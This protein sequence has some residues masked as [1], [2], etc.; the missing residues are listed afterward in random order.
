MIP[1]RLDSWEVH[2]PSACVL[3]EYGAP[4]VLRWQQVELPQPAAGQIRLRVRAAGVGP[5]DLEIR[6]GDLRAIF[7]LTADS[8]LGFEASGV[9]DALG[10]GVQ[11]I[12]VGDEVA[13]WLPSLGGYAEYALASSW[14]IKSQA[15]SFVDAAALP[16]SVEA[17]VGV[18]DQLGVVE[19][20]IV[21]ILG[22]AGSVGTIATQIAL[23][24]GATVI[25]AASPRDHELLRELG[26]APVTYGENLVEQVREISS[27]VD[28]VMDAAGRGSLA[29]AIELAGGTE[30]VIT[31]SDPHAQDFGVRLSAPTPDRAPGAVAQGMALLA[32]GKL[33]MKQRRELPMQHA[34]EAHRLLES[35]ETHDKVVLTIG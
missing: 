17:A 12:S 1:V 10:E 33:R 29:E 27:R 19:G 25:A 23:S 22:G 24:R 21:L 11:G 35:G 4:A 7:S 34:A 14:T 6:R 13:A 9:A 30:R 18:L 20:D 31:L 8:V 3:T 15:V 28:A 16:A 2:V 5:T 26:A 32:E